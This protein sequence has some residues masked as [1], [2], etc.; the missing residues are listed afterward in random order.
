MAEA[1]EKVCPLLTIAAMADPR[2]PVGEA[3]C[4]RERCAWWVTSAV[5]YRAGEYEYRRECA[6]TKI[7]MSL[8]GVAL[9]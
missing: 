6:L 3:A 2:V 8:H 9:R 7:A 5:P 4:L 1:E